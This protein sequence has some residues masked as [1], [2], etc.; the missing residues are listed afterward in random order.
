M[1]LL[2]GF[3]VVKSLFTFLRDEDY[4]KSNV[5]R[6]IKLPADN[7]NRAA[8]NLTQI[9][10]YDRLN[11]VKYDQRN[12]CLL[13]LMYHAGLRVSEACGIKWQDI[14]EREDGKG[15][16]HI[17]SKGDRPRDVLLQPDMYQELMALPKTIIYGRFESPY[18]FPGYN[19][20]ALSAN[21]VL[22]IVREAAKLAGIQK[23]VSPH[24]L[25]HAHAT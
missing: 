2:P 3:I 20:K 19:G 12:H 24:W 9:E 23:P 11:A 18:V 15:Q 5:A 14:T 21:Q 4:R 17:M 6:F 25:R 22:R 10:V 16:I 8:R 1:N 13:H 7:T